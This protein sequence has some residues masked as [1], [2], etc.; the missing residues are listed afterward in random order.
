MSNLLKQLKTRQKILL[1]VSLMIL[2]LLFIEALNLNTQWKALN[3]GKQVELTDLTD[4][5]FSL[6]EKQAN[7]GDLSPEQAM[8]IARQ[9]IETLR[10]GNNDY[11]FILDSQGKMLS[12][13]IKPDLV[14]KNLTSSQDAN[15]V[16]M[17][18]EMSR[19]ASNQGDAFVEYMFPRAGSNEPIPKLSYARHF[20]K[21]DWVVATGVYIDD[22]KAE[23]YEEIQ[24]AIIN[25]LITMTIAVSLGMLLARTIAQPIVDLKELM[26]QAASQHD[27]TLRSD[28]RSR[29]EVGQMSAAFNE[30]LES[31]DDIIT[32]VNSSAQ[33]VSASATELSAATA[34]TQ[35]GMQE[36]H[37]ESEMVAAAV[38][39]MSATVHDVANNTESTAQATHEASHAASQGKQQVR[40]AVDAVNE[41]SMQLEQSGSLTS[42]LKEESANIA[43]ILEVINNIAEQT[44]L[45][46]LNAAIEAARAGEQGRGFAVVADEVR[47]LAQRTAQSTGEIQQVITSLQNGAEN[48]ADAMAKSHQVAIGVVNKA[49]LAD[50]ALDQIVGGVSQIDDMTTQIAST[51]EQQSAV[52]EEI[53]TNVSRINDVSSECA[54]AADQVAES[55]ES[56]AELSEHLRH[57][58]SSFKVSA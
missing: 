48:A 18:D 51:A 30:M 27:L 38:N 35:A 16:R 29:D 12:H 5:A 36:Q 49:Q 17:F 39:E 9:Q 7:R 43:S 13:P 52:T 2:A 37:Q 33:Q 3:H 44:N 32:D 41:L 56:L 20:P 34:Q 40:E 54:T 22:I 58:T 50:Q 55:S 4:T 42:Q 10:Y 8:D 19:Q 31:F 14:G 28:Y 6:I 46:A 15:G 25:L 24:G 23:F 1:L 47:T 26:G 21:W 53:N 11:F 57:L 45:L